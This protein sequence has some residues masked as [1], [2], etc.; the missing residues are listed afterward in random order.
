MKIIITI[1]LGCALW[2]QGQTPSTNDIAQTFSPQLNYS[3]NQ[4]AGLRWAYRQAINAFP[5]T[6][7]VGEVTNII[8]APTFIEWH[9]ELVRGM[10]ATA[11]YD[12]ARQRKDVEAAK[13]TFQD[14]RD[15]WAEL[16]PEQ[17]QAV[18]NAAG[19]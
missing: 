7:I 15:R 4:L 9:R 2:A 6:N 17:R 13:P 18:L 14:L 1:L 3:T 19:L 16:S 10:C 8:A 5:Q 12:Y 11:A